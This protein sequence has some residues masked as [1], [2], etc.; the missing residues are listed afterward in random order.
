[1]RFGTEPLRLPILFLFGF[2]SALLLP[3]CSDDEPTTPSHH[4]AIRDYSDMEDASGIT[5]ASFEGVNSEVQVRTGQTNVIDIQVRAEV[6]APSAEDAEDFADAIQMR[7]ELDRTHRSW[8][9]DYPTV[10][11]DVTITLD[12]IIEVP[13]GMEVEVEAINGSF[14]V[15]GVLGP[16]I[17]AIQNGVVEVRGETGQLTVSGTNASVDIALDALDGPLSSTTVN[18]NQKLAFGE[19]DTSVFAATVNGAIELTLPR[20]YDGDL[21]AQVQNGSVDVLVTLSGAQVTPTQVTGHIGG[22]SEN[23][24]VLRAVN[25][26]IDVFMARVARLHVSPQSSGNTIG[27]SSSSPPGRSGTGSPSGTNPARS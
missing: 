20:P 25:G 17:L 1:M 5:F 2:A 9:F 3:A 19:G 6:D 16:V 23:S 11:R 4:S 13:E 21:D 14:D 24:V 12:W 22:E 26:G 7:T 18:G 8:W 27:C 10:P 15:D